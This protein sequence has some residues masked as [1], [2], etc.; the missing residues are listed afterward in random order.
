MLPM[1]CAVVFSLF[2]GG[3][4]VAIGLQLGIG[5]IGG[6]LVRTIARGSLRQVQRGGDEVVVEKIVRTKGRDLGSWRLRLYSHCCPQ[7]R[8]LFG[9]GKWEVVVRKYHGGM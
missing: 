5:G 3:G 4:G 1:S 7:W 2:L 8:G 6:V 9:E